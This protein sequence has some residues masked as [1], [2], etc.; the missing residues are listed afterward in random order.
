MKS[1]IERLVRN[2]RKT[3]MSRVIKALNRLHNKEYE[4]RYE[5]NAETYE[6]L[7]DIEIIHQAA[8]DALKE[9]KHMFE[10]MLCEIDKELV[11]NMSGLREIKVGEWWYLIL[12]KPEKIPL[13]SGY[14]NVVLDEY[15]T[16]SSTYHPGEGYTSTIATDKVLITKKGG[17]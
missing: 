4:E 9:E 16:G 6:L 15:W 10:D 1:I 2:Y 3:D 7:R 13:P 17:Y 5:R 14:C 11:E 8:A 12:G